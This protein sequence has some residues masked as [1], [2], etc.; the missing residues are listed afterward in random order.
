MIYKFFLVIQAILLS[1]ALSSC[2][3]GGSE[4]T[5]KGL[6]VTFAATHQQ[7]PDATLQVPSVPAGVRTFLNSEGVPITLTKAYL[8][9]WS[10][11]LKSDCTTTLFTQL[12][13][14]IFNRF[15]LPAAIAQTETTSTQLGVS[16]VIDL[17][18]ADL[19]EIELGT[20]HPPPGDYCGM[21]VE[22]RK[23]DDNTQRLPTDINMINRLLYLEGQYIPL[24]NDQPTTFKVDIAKAPL[25]RDLALA[26]SLILSS[27]HRTAR[28][29]VSVHYDRWF[30]ALDLS[31]LNDEVQ[32][33]W[34]LH[35]LLSSL[36]DKNS[37]IDE[38]LE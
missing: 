24:G 20:I 29:V 31:A 26:S 18:A 37:I 27:D 30:D 13:Q 6:T 4:H 28:L 5:E 25:P 12:W 14:P 23:A 17:L 9:I 21:T 16:N 33:D 8:V 2:N 34:L 10:I 3:S 32:Q 35:N 7:T 36:H 38:S 22:L 19:T 15:L 1:F 11:E